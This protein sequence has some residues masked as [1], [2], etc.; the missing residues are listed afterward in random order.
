MKMSRMILLMACIST[1]AGAAPAGYRTVSIQQGAVCVAEAGG[2]AHCFARD[3]LRKSL[4]L[5]SRDGDRIAFISEAGPL[6]T[7]QRPLATLRIADRH[8]QQLAAIAIKPLGPD[9]VA[10]GMRAVEYLEW[11]GRDRILVGGSIN[12]SS[13]EYLVVDTASGQVVQELIDDGGGIAVSPDGAHIATIGD[14]PH[15]SQ[16]RPRT[17]KLVVDGNEVLSLAA[18]GVSPDSRPLWSPD[19]KAL[20]LQVRGRGE[21]PGVLVWNRGRRSHSLTLLPVPKR[22]DARRALAWQGGDLLAATQAEPALPGRP[23][24]AVEALVLKNAATSS[25]PALVRARPPAA[26]GAAQTR[27]R[28]KEEAL[29]KGAQEADVWCADCALR[30]LPRAAGPLSE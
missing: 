5:M 4:P 20:A 2:P 25:A 29:R 26:S 16:G 22:A 8:G 21:R 11:V 19:G 27:S 6:D 3:G 14:A 30:E 12:P 17:G 7:R 23:G 24:A 28:L 9:E 18:L 13:G 10:S 1:G 15:F